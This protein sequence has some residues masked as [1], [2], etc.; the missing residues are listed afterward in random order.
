MSIPMNDICICCHV[1]KYLK[2]GRAAGDEA[3]TMEFVRRIMEK[4]L[5]MPADMDS[6]WMGAM[7][8]QDMQEIYGTDPDALRE[9]KK[10]SNRFALERLDT[11]ESRIEKASDRVFA[12]LQFAIL[13][14]YID[15]SALRG[16]VDFS[17]LEAL[18]D[19]YHTLDLDKACYE[20]FCSDLK[21]GK[22]LLYITDNAGEIVFDRI[23]AERIKEVYPQLEITFCVRGGP[24]SND[25]TRED[26]KEAGIS[27]PV[28]DNGT[29]IGGTVLKV[30][31]EDLKQAVS[32]A[33]VIL[34]KGMG[35]A[36][37]MFGCGYNVYYGFLVKC[38]RFEE[39]FKKPK[40]A[41]M[42]IH[43]TYLEN[44]PV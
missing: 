34:A 4:L 19:S 35:N 22:K 38:P 44:A 6:A 26:A 5:K 8:D 20:K 15:F 3:Q 17:K 29:S 11:I 27:F 10:F 1:T 30:A 43:D 13:G 16:E 37:S 31:G 24:V 2:A 42:F 39:F 28:I 9:E 21:A 7:A 32:Q 14:N 40:L 25:A 18:L 33:D 36:E 41:P 12:A 23:L